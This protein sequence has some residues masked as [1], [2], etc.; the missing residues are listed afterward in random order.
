MKNN[1]I[2]AF[3]LILAAVCRQ[4]EPQSVASE[5]LGA[6][7]SFVQNKDDFSFEIK[8]STRVTGA[9]CYRI[10]MNSG[11]WL[12]DSLVNEPLWWHWLDVIV[13]DER[14]SQSALLFIGGGT[15]FDSIWEIDSL[16]LA[17]AVQTKSVIAHI[18]NIPFQPLTYIATDTVTRYED[19]LIA[20][21]WDKY[22]SGG[23]QEK[24]LNWLARFPMT[25]AVVRGMD[26]VETL[27]AA[28]SNPVTSFVVSGA[29]KRGWT[30]WTTAAV[31]D[32][33]IGMAPLVIDLLNLVPSF[34]HHHKAYGAWSPAVAEYE[35]FGIMDWMGSE[36]FDRMLDHV[37]PYEFREVFTMPKL[38]VN[39]TLDE[40]FLP[41]SWQFYWDSI[42]GPK[43]LQYVP[44]GNHGLAGSYNTENVFSFFNSVI[45]DEPLPKMDWKVTDTSFD[46]AVDPNSDYE[47]AL[48][49]ITNT[50]ARD[51]RIWVVG[52]TWEKT[53]LEK[54]ETGIY[55][56]P[57]PS[58]DGYTASFVEVTFNKDSQH[59][60][61]LSTGSKV[62]PDTYSF[63][64]FVSERP[65]GS[66]E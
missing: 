49:Q 46:V 7:K 53:V 31:D 2:V 63:G 30:T 57:A 50:E 16:S 56:I 15:R 42:P 25:R 32:R 3:V 6:L 48:W 11:K 24:D 28:K 38:I 58:A 62:L 61:T 64:D 4:P 27:T 37:E 18:S 55:S 65:K 43:A 45:H 44:N 52:K 14:D 21:G 47:I 54:N 29:S 23:A 8:D 13:P 10:R 59:P 19:D 1:L 39:G 17:K 41:D 5:P 60:I 9:S 34:N 40:F 22:L 36:E 51:F 26:V 12:N 66:R 20:Y 35:N 33:V